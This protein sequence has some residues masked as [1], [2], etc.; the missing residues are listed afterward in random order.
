MH[1]TSFW[2]F[3][4]G[5]TPEREITWTG[6]KRVSAIF[7]WGIHRWNFKTLACMVHKIWHA[8]DEQMDART[9]NLKPI[10]SHNF[11]EIGGITIIFWQIK[12]LEENQ[13][14][15]YT[16]YTFLVD[17]GLCRH[18][19]RILDTYKHLLSHTICK[20]EK[21]FIQTCLHWISCMSN[22][23]GCYE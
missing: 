5:I 7:P 1:Q 22:H 16:R 10:C 18:Y 4:G 23:E 3:Q 8:C 21:L 9:D 6:K 19:H 17:E 13:N 15:Y 12:W 14:K 20:G 11:F 2:F